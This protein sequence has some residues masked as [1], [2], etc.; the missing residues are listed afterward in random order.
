MYLCVRAL[1][2][3]CMHLIGVHAHV[4]AL[5]LQGIQSSIMQIIVAGFTMSRMYITPNCRC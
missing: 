1:M 2:Q 5:V 4:L 3:A